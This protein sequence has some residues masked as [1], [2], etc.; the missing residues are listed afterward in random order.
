MPGPSFVLVV[1]EVLLELVE[2]EVELGVEPPRPGRERVGERHAST[3]RA[4]TVADSGFDGVE[5]IRNG[6]ARPGREDDDDG[7]LLAPETMRDARL[8]QGR[9]PDAARAVEDGQP[10]GHQVRDDH[11]DLA[12][13]AEEEQRVELGVVERRQ[14]LVRAR[15]CRD[16]RSRRGL[17]ELET[18]LLG[19][20]RDVALEGMLEHVDV[21]AAPELALERHRLGL[22]PPRSGS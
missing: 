12:L 9:L 11:L 22:R 3:K 15:R 14:P 10:R 6:V 13:A 20:S 19:Q 16:R 5:Q 2:D 7:V 8:Q 18:R 1:E 4:G 21:A 17:G